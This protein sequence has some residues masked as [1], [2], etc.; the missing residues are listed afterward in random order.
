MK[1][2]KSRFLIVFLLCFVAAM[3]SSMAQEERANY[4]ESKVPEY[5]L[6]ELLRMSD[7]TKVNTVKDWTEKRRP[8]VLRLFEKYEFGKMPGKLQGMHFVLRESGKVLNGKAVRKQVTVYFTAD[9]A[10]PKMDLLIYLPDSPK[11]VPVFLALNF[12]GNQTIMDDKAIF[13]NQNWVADVEGFGIANHRAMEASRGAEHSSWPI[14]MII[15][16]GYGLAT[17]YY[18]D[19]DPDFNDSFQNGIHPLFY[20]PG[21]I[22]PAPDEWG[23]IGAWAWG[24][25]RAM[26]YLETDKDID[27]KHIALMGHSRLGK[28][29]LWAGAQDKR[30][31]I[32][33]SNESG[34][35]GA[36]L[37]KR[38]VGETVKNINDQFPHWF[39][40]NFKQFNDKEDKLPFDQH[41]LIALMAP[42]PVYVASAKEDQWADPKGEFL[43]AKLAG[44]VYKLYGLQALP[45]ANMP[46]VDKPVM[47]QV[48]YHI[49]SGKHDVTDF[50]WQQY[51]TFAEKHFR[52]N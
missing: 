9:E 11:P 38:L 7:G 40:D 27:A 1:N 17:A 26:D 14:E 25:S 8:E 16:R 18:G 39:C 42:R 24:L 21:Q 51:L 5:K 34:C 43:S 29:A 3:Y 52:K 10:G 6:P 41:M 49:R 15:D 28:A 37:S 36:A 12:Y 23:S 30:F 50:D 45:A 44:P 33:I 35:G 48:A 32:V 46:P 19:I 22:K 2:F 13:M 4:D 31:A 20:K 47:G